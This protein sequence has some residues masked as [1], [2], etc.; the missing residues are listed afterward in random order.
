MGLQGY[1]WEQRALERAKEQGVTQVTQDNFVAEVSALNP[2]LF[3]TDLIL[4]L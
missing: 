4:T 1:S 2:E 3:L